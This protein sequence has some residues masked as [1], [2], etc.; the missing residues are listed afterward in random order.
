MTDFRGLLGTL[1]TAKVD[2]IVVGGVA[3]TMHGSARLTSDLDVVYSRDPGNIPRL[4]RALAPL[5]PYPRGA[6]KGL[7]FVWDE[8]TVRAGLNFTLATDLG[9]LDLFG[10]IPGGGAFP[11]LLPHTIEVMLFGEAVRVLDLPTLIRTKRAAGRPRDFEAVA[12][13]EALEE[14][15][16]S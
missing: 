1:H 9:D 13:L 2:F 12:E 5:H 15:R 8:R 16:R 3:A 14:E 6:P 4:A 11:D 10:E 7:P